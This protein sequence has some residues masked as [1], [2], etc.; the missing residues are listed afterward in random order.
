MST[1]GSGG[2]G[3]A[4][5]AAT[6]PVPGPIKLAITPRR[7]SGEDGESSREFIELFEQAARSNRWLQDICVIQFP[8]YL[9]H[10]ASKWWR[11]F[12]NQRN[13]AAAASGSPVIPPTW[14]EVKD[15]F[16][17][18]FNSDDVIGV[19]LTL[20]NRKQR[21]DESPEQFVFDII[22]LCERVDDS[23]SD[24]RRVRF[25]LRN[26]KEYYLS[27][28]MPLDPKTPEE[29]LLHM[30]R[31]TEMKKLAERSGSREYRAFPVAEEGVALEMREMVRQTQRL[32][33][34]IQEQRKQDK[35][36]K[37]AR[38]LQRRRESRVD[39]LK[40]FNCS[41]TGHIARHCRSPPNQSGRN[42]QRNSAFSA[43][44]RKVQF[45]NQSG[46]RENNRGNFRQENNQE[47]RGQ[48][49]S[50]D[51]RNWS[52]EGSQERR[53]RQSGNRNAAETSR[54]PASDRP[55]NAPT[56]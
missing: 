37:E 23:M 42:D 44:D 16:L 53:W 52:R 14:Q 39:G 33:E 22:S 10:T 18:A 40:C 32:V 43:R 6:P 41:K 34:E 24:E 54:A 20:D 29:I 48:H 12:K 21:S 26:M 45:E 4:G 2:G 11:A 5:G 47:N 28:I 50:Q 3:G 1:G 25:L 31:L 7:F 35:A 36:E 13:R 19:E 8:N 30:R 15:A 27:R 17:A 49:R 46:S 51:A 9:T 38:Q 56:W 55:E